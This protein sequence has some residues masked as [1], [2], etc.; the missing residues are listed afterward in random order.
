MH[1]YLFEVATVAACFVIASVSLNLVVAR[2]GLL[3]LGHGAIVG[4]GAYAQAIL[5]VDHGFPPAL[6]LVCA[7][8]VAAFVGAL[9]AAVS[10]GL[11]DEQ[12][13]VTTLA[14]SLFVTNVLVNWTALTKGAYGI[15]QI[16]RFDIGGFGKSQLTFLFISGIVAGLAYWLFRTVSESGFGA[17][18]RAAA[19]DRSMAES[20]G[21]NVLRLRIVAFTLASAGAGLAGGLFAMHWGYIS[22]ELFHLHLSVLILAMVIVGGAQT[23]GGAAIGA[24][25]LILIPEALRFA[26]FD[27][28]SAGPLRQFVFGMLILVAIFLQYRRTRTASAQGARS[29]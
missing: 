24:L 22:P 19:F 1:L 3:S 11:D 28:V 5:S 26:A 9:L 27:A 14:F 13:A 4:V 23:T 18:L 16:P 12:F 7:V 6:A 25:V 21:A 29:P 10:V 15:A 8:A 17:I 2:A 20:I